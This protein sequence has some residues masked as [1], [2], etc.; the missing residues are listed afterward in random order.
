M[1]TTLVPS[2][3]NHISDESQEVSNLIDEI[4]LAGRGV[5]YG[6]SSLEPPSTQ[7]LQ[8]ILG[9]KP[10]WTARSLLLTAVE[11]YPTWS[12]IGVGTR[13]AIICEAAA[14]ISNALTTGG[15]PG[16]TAPQQ[17]TPGDATHA[18]YNVRSD[19]V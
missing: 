15:I 11:I 16:S 1:P 2:S 18:V 12:A 8:W 3:S 17:P 7:L 19:T 10:A 9:E 13:I 4:V 5:M 14:F 6:K